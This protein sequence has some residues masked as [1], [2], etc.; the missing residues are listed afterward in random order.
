M[1]T[2]IITEVGVVR[3]VV[4]AV[5]KRTMSIDAP[6]T[7]AG[8][9]EGDSV[10]INGVCLTVVSLDTGRFDVEVVPESLARSNLG[11]L[12]PGR[13]VNLERPVP[14]A[15]RFDGHVVQGHVDGV[16]SVR[17]IAR[18]G[19]SSRVWLDAPPDQHRYVVEKGSVA[20]DGVSLTV[21]AIDDAGFEVVLVP[22]TLD[23]TIL[24]TRA[25]G[26]DVNVEVDVLAKYVERLLESRR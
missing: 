25:V 16:A 8:L 11:G 12:E 21:S 26:E 20:I 24:G 7:V 1:F 23:A 17:S 4:D 13:V 14:A 22:H 18:D 9:K 10:A 3:S 6:A 19:E 2:G 5:G 15:G